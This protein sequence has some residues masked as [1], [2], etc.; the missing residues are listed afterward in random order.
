M[1]MRRKI[2][3][4]APEAVMSP[5]QEEYAIMAGP[6]KWKVGKD[7]QDGQEIKIIEQDPSSGDIE[8]DAK[9]HSIF[10]DED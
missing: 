5:Y 1:N 8:I 3:Y 2:E 7:G 6:S 9:G 10:D 4:V